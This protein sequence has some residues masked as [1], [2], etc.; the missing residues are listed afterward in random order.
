M[1]ILKAGL[2]EE[3]DKPAKGVR[4]IFE[5]FKSEKGI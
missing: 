3:C 5:T 1:S 4:V 2:K